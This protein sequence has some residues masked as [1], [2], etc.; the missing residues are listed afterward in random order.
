MILKS[1]F[2]I[3]VFI[4][5]A[6]AA[7]AQE[8][9]NAVK[10]NDLEK[11]KVLIEKDASLVNIKDEA[12]NTPLHHA[13]IIGSI[14]TIKL[15]LSKGADINARNTQL[16]TPLHEAIQSKKEN[17][18]ALLIEKGADLNKT[19][20]HNRNTGTVKNGAYLRLNSKHEIRNRV[21]SN[22]FKLPKSK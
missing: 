17:I 7:Q 16:N 22:K 1:F 14:E 18:S 11:V 3:A 12:G 19:N 8:I 20:I 9:F 5:A 6:A 15:L 4:L 13:A 2:V 21:V 10:N